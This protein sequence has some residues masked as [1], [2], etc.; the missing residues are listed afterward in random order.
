MRASQA[1]SVGANLPPPFV[2]AGVQA[3][4]DRLATLLAEI[5]TRDL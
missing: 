2:T 5:E 3:E 1:Q 4:A